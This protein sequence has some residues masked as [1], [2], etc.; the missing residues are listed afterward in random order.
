MHDV[1][2]VA[3]AAHMTSIPPRQASILAHLSPPPCLT[4]SP[5]RAK[6]RVCL[7]ECSQVIDAATLAYWPAGRQR[8][9]V[10]EIQIDD[11]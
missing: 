4:R 1:G 6:R 7:P 5:L 8:N 9:R 2:S 3:A 11:G 10:M